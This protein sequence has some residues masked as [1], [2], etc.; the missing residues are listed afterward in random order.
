MGLTRAELELAARVAERY[1][2]GNGNS[3]FVGVPN[4]ATAE[5]EKAVA[6]GRVALEDG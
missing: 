1:P 2:P 5:V 6:E 4:L 3:Y